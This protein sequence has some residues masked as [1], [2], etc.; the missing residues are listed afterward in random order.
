MFKFIFCFF[1]LFL[2]ADLIKELNLGGGSIWSLDLDDFS[3]NCGCGKYP[4]LTALNRGL[5]QEK[6]R[7]ADC[8]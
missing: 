4:L 5:V 6:L 2:Q 8:T 7:M 3:G 1:D